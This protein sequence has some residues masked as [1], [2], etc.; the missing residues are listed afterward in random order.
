[1]DYHKINS[2]IILLG[3]V[4]VAGLLV[5]MI[6]RAVALER[7][8]DAG[9]ANLT[10]LIILGVCAV[11]YLIIIATL[12]QVIIPWIMEKLSG[13]DLQTLADN[14]SSADNEKVSTAPVDIEKIKQ[15]ADRQYIDRLNAKIRVFLEYTHIVVGPYITH[16]ELS[17]LD[18][19]IEC[20]AREEALPDNLIPIK[21][22]KLKNPDL[23]HFGWNMAEH[24]GV[25]KK[26]EVVAWLKRVFAGMEKLENS[27]ITGKLFDGHDKKCII[28]NTVDIPK[29]L[30]GL[31]G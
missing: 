5:A 1:M 22:G 25:G 23:F 29:F 4:I 14:A 28:P 8:A 2:H 7:G 31:K 26:K 30:A 12:S 6:G 19:Y 20:Y 3:I 18:K 10:F 9:T 17:R 15:D 21:P 13:K 16:D 27:Y 24:F 11:I